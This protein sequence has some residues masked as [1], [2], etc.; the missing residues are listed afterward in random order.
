[1]S[2]A[3]FKGETSVTDLV[4]RLFRIQGKGSQAAIKQATDT[5]LKANP[6]L[7]DLNSIPIG[8]VITVPDT[9]PSINPSERASAISLQIAGAVSRAQQSVGTINQS[10]ADVNGRAIDAATSVAEVTKS[11]DLLQAAST[12]PDLKKGISQIVETSRTM[13][14]DLQSAAQSNTDDIAKLRDSLAA[15]LQ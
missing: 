4:G 9:G 15:L 1:M 13:L 8:T 11:K 6:N 3:I 10:L 14:K 7:Q 5:L 12:N 2:V